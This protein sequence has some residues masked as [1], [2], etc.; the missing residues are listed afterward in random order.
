M[1]AQP[2]SEART[3]VLARVLGPYLVIAA[4]A[5]LVR[6]PDLSKLLAEFQ[7][8]VLWSW[9]TGAFVLL[10]GLIVIAVH[11][12]W[13]GVAAILI[14]VLG[15]LTGVKGVLLLVIPQRYL[16]FGD[17]MINA[18]GWWLGTMAVTSL[19]GLYLTYVG[20]SPTHRQPQVEPARNSGRHL[21]HA[22]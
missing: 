19:V 22:A 10:T 15:W 16:S 1:N 11:Q 2:E 18:K 6:A 12:Y 7:G 20:W 21:R 3:R 8:N 9:V 13:R 4:L 5:A 14:S 17:T